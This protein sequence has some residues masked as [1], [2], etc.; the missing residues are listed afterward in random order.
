LIEKTFEST[1]YIYNKF[2]AEIKNE[3]KI[4]GKR[5]KR[6]QKWLS[7]CKRGSKNRYKVKLEMPE[8]I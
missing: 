8:N 4:N 5:L 6:L 1:R 7:R 2:L 3:V